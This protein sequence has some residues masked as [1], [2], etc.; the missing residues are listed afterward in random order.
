MN[1]RS[2]L[3]SGNVCYLRR[4]FGVARLVCALA[5]LMALLPAAPADAGLDQWTTNGPA[6]TPA[7]SYLSPST[8]A[9]PRPSTRAPVMPG[10]WLAPCS[11]APTGWNLGAREYR[12][13]GRLCPRSGHRSPDDI[14]DLRRDQWRLYRSGLFGDV[15]EHRRRHELDTPGYHTCARFRYFGG[16]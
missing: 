13:P 10:C 7:L 2:S 6:R 16:S 15:Q 1:M 12:S 8:R 5:I 11:R 9:R 3:L 14:H 4:R